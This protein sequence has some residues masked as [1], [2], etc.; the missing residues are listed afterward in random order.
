MPSRPTAVSDTPECWPPLPLAEWKDTCAT[1]HMWTQIVGKTRMALTPLINHWWNVPLYVSSR[2]LTTS[3]I[4]YGERVFEIEFDFL[5]HI[6]DIRCSDGGSRQLLLASRSVADFYAE[7]M[8]ALKSLAIEVH[9][10]KM[11]VEVADPI[12]FDQDRKH[13]A[14]DR[15]YAQRFWR[16][17][18]SATDVLQVFRSGFI[19]K[20]SPVHFFWGSFDLALTR[21]SGRRAPER[22]DAD[23]VL[24]KIMREAY[25]H[26]VISAGWWPGAGEQDAAF[27]AYAAPVPE[28]LAQQQVRPEQAFYNQGLGEFLLN[29]EDV[30]RAASPTQALMEFLESTYAA[31]ASLAKWDRAA[32]ERLPSSGQSSAERPSP[33]EGAA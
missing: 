2:G 8:A 31:A 24:R 13:A 7:Y 29:Y 4:P 21:F 32:L 23:P 5:S 27:Y 16:V 26:E 30:R 18:V 33:T 12:P 10:W 15:E 3:S 28:G 17:L 22:N 20:T 19:G 14:Y 25:S 1:L 6:L 9:I 11:P